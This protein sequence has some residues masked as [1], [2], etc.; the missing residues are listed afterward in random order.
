MK[1]KAAELSSQL[2]G[3]HPELQSVLKK[4]DAWSIKQGLPEVVVTHVSR[5]RNE[6]RSIYVPV[7]LAQGMAEERAHA[8]ADARFSWHLVDCA[9][10]VRNSHYT[11]AQLKQ[12]MGFLRPLCEAPLWELLSHDV[13]RG[14]HLHLGKRD[15]AWRKAY[16]VRP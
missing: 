6:M 7:Y 16:K 9:A 3:A 11:P 14:E 10:D 12:V 8:A 15:F 13:G 5:T 4:L 1:F 2:A